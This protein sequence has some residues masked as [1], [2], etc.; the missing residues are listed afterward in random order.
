MAELL[1]ELFSEEI[2]ARMQANAG[3]ELQTALQRELQKIGIA[4]DG[5][6][7]WPFVTPRRLAVWVKDLPVS[8]SASETELKGP[9]V[10]APEAALQG[11]LKKNNLTQA[12]LTERD[13]VY[14]VVVKK[15]GQQTADVLKPI[16]EN[17]LT[18]FPWP[19]S[20]R[21]GAYDAVWVRPLHSILCIFDGKVVPV[22]FGPVT[23]SNVTYGH[24]FLSPEKITITNAGEYEEKLKKAHVL[25]D[26]EGR[27]KVIRDQANALAHKHGLSVRPDERLLDEVTGL[28]EW[29]VVLMGTIDA[30]YMDLPPEVLVSEMRGHQKYFTLTPTQPSPLK[31][32]GKGGGAVAPFFL[33][34]ANMETS[35]GAVVAGNE[36]VL[37]ARLAD[38][39]FFWDQDRKKSLDQWAEGLKSVTFHAKLGMIADKVSRISTLAATLA[40]HI[41]GADAKKVARAAALCKA[42]LVTGMVGEFPELQGVMGR[43]YALHQKEDAAVADAVRDHYKPLGPTDAVPAEPTAICVALSD[44]LDTLV[45]MFAIGEKPTGSK[46]PFALRRAALG[47]IRII[48]ENKIRLPLNPLLKNKE[49][50][51]FFSDRLKVQLKDSGIRHDLINAVFALG[52]DDLVRLVERVTALQNFL[53][54][55]DGANLLAAYKRAANILSIEEKKDKKQYSGLVE[56]KHL[57]AQEERSLFE[58]LEKME[59]AVKPLLEKEHFVGAM[60]AFSRLRKPVDTFFDKVLVND[61]DAHVRANRLNLLASLRAALDNIANFALIEG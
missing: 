52:E 20:M 54:T 38:G 22:K 17:I 10:G 55:D 32:E 53:A 31:G 36:R 51:D 7:L 45:S 59:A 47:V 30:K 46:D 15:A 25:A 19:K 57:Q 33:I 50:P 39:R 28:V 13:G 3:E 18:N 11:F 27:K 24:R 8:Q 35:G 60:E 61:K 44:K 29:P 1:L 6:N 40:A 14:F 21:W 4:V 26:F 48:L 43:Y 16:I 9:K 5:R 23:A 42:D 37:R 2:P 34:T 49:L 58:A 56:V 41:K 12:D